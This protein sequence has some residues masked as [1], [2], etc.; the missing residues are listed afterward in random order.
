M[1][2]NEFQGRLLY[3]TE[4]AIHLA[5]ER[6]IEPIPA[7]V[8]YRV[9]EGVEQL[10][11]LDAER[12]LSLLY[13]E[14]NEVREWIN[15]GVETTIHGVTILRCPVAPNFINYDEIR[16]LRPRE[17]TPFVIGVPPPPPGWM[18]RNEQGV[19]QP[20]ESLRQNGKYSLFHTTRK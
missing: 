15:L 7:P 20:E 9:S 5:Q 1:N 6:V 17:E 18:L 10:G 19:P 13:R 11:F 16:R 12:F 4:Q 8:M 3:W 14:D 2:R